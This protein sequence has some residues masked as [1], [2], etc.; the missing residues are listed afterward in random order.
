MKDENK[1]LTFQFKMLCISHIKGLFKGDH[2]NSMET[3]FLK[4]CQGYMK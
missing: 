2:L 1:L 3:I 4:F